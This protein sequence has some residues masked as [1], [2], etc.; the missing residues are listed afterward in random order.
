MTHA[1]FLRAIAAAPDDGLLRQAYADWLHE[2]G[3]E[4]RAEFVR[5][6]L[7]LEPLRDRLDLPR[8]REMLEREGKLLWENEEAWL[9]PSVAALRAEGYDAS[10]GPYFRRGVP[11][12]VAVSLEPLLEHGEALLDAH[13]TIRQVAVFDISCECG[14][15]AEW[16]G[17]RRIDRLELADDLSD[18]DVASLLSSSHFRAV[19]MVRL[20]DTEGPRPAALWEEPP[21]EWPERMQV[22]VVDLGG[23]LRGRGGASNPELDNLAAWFI[24]WGR[25]MSIVRPSRAK[26]ALCPNLEQNLHPGRDRQ[27]RQILFGHGRYDTDPVVFAYFDEEGSLTESRR[28]DDPGCCQSTEDYPAWLAKEIGYTPCPIWMREFQTPEGLGIHM[29]PGSLGAS[30]SGDIWLW[31]HERK[32]VINWCNTPWASGRTGEITDT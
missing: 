32:Y 5:L 19:P 3:Q 27:G 14:R 17:L 7:E 12:L 30:G 22:E 8:V 6:Q 13:P 15:L 26:F 11:D 10:H 28:A 31:L 18:K 16:A 24:G 4:V 23:S 2:D 20:W 29:M 21:E 9:G 25:R 1:D